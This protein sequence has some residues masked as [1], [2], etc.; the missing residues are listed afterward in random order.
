M[1]AT[2]YTTIKLNAELAEEARR[3]G[4][5]YGRSIASQVG[6]WAR[7]GQ[8]LERV[9]ELRQGLVRKVLEDELNV[10]EISEDERAFLAELVAANSEAEDFEG[11]FLRA[12]GEVMLED[13][14]STAREHLAAGRAIVYADDDTPEGWAIRQ[15]PDG[16]RELFTYVD[17]VEKTKALHS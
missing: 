8:A 6:H 16:R 17:G 5:L 10:A 15:Y 4:G 9:P 2:R 3:E 12:V 14:G 7:L 11:K 1:A 13:R